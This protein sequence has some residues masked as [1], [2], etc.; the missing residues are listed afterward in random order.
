MYM[1]DNDNNIKKKI[2]II[3]IIIEIIIII[4]IIMR[5]NK[6]I[7]DGDNNGYIYT[8]NSNYND[9]T[10]YHLYCC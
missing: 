3:I 7:N 1:D 4:T 8:G 2:I 10:C 6:H 9:D 5:M